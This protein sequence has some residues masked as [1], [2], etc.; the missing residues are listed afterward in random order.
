MWHWSCCIH[1]PIPRSRFAIN[2]TETI[3][4]CISLW[5]SLWLPRMLVRIGRKKPKRPLRSICQ[6]R[7]YWH[8][9]MLQLC[10]VPASRTMNNNSASNAEER[11]IQDERKKWRLH[12]KNAMWNVIKNSKEMYKILRSLFIGCIWRI[13]WRLIYKIMI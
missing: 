2:V 6:Y 5:L 8:Y 9:I 10:L 12:S 7:F 1:F 4:L 13:D 11:K 3:K